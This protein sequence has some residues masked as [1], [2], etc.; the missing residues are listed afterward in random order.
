MTVGFD[1]P[2][3][4]SLIRD[5]LSSDEGVMEEALLCGL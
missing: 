4:S 1:D 5:G 2:A 3:K